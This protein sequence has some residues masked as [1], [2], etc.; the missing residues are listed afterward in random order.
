MW[1]DTQLARTRL[2]STGALPLGRRD[3]NPNAARRTAIDGNTALAASWPKRG[4][5]ASPVSAVTGVPATD[6]ARPSGAVGTARTARAAALG[7]VGVDED[8]D[9][10]V[11]VDGDGVDGDGVDEVGER[12]A[13]ALGEEAPA[14]ARGASRATAPP[15]DCPGVCTVP[16]GRACADSKLFSR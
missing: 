6:E 7:D 2:A 14:P 10:D 8:R 3:A 4:V 15:D 9:D 11:G 16:G 12:R 5:L 13:V 1:G